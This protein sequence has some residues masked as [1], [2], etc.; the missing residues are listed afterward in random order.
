MK[1]IKLSPQKEA[2]LREKHKE[3]FEIIDLGKKLNQGLFGKVA[4]NSKIKM[5]DK[6]MFDG[7]NVTGNFISGMALMLF[8]GF[9]TKPTKI[10]PEH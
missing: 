10:K 5:K 3:A 1:Q 4:C 8:A 6:C 2:E 7:S 9:T